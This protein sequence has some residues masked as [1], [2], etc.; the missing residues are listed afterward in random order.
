MPN[1]LLFILFDS[2]YVPFFYKFFP[3]FRPGSG[4]AFGIRIQIQAAIECGFNA[5]PDPKHW[6]P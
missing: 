5:D 3:F 2:N 1:T 6:F 4:S